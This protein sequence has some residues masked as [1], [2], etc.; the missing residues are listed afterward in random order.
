MNDIM[1]ALVASTST[2]KDVMA[3]GAKGPYRLTVTV[4]GVR[5]VFKVLVKK[6]AITHT[7]DLEAPEMITFDWDEA[8]KLGW[9]KAD[10]RF[11]AFELNTPDIM[12]EQS[13]PTEDQ[14][15]DAA[16]VIKRRFLAWREPPVELPPDSLIE[17][18]AMALLARGKQLR[19]R[20]SAEIRC[21]KLEAVLRDKLA[22]ETVDAILKTI[23]EEVAIEEF[24]REKKLKG[25]KP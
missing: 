8:V 20:T 6:T 13:R 1:D 15:R 16:Q 5:R 4:D 23:D 22:P 2:I 7:D 17:E 24:R 12:R 11:E 21:M 9:W 19:A 25:F 18:C 10:A 3:R 14:V